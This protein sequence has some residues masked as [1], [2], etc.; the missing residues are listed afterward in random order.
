WIADLLSIPVTTGF[1]AGISIHIIISQLPGVLGLPDPASHI[2][3]QRLATLLGELGRTNPYTLAIG[4]GLLA[5]ILMSERI[6]SRIPGALIGLVLATVAVIALDLERRGV[7][8]LGDV[9]GAFPVPS[10]PAVSFS[11]V[12]GLIPLTLIIVVTIMMQTAATTRSFPSRPDEPPDVDRDFIGV[13]AGSVLAG[14]I[15]AFPVD[16]SPPRTAIVAESG[17]PPPPPPPPPAPP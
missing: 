9:H 2:M 15:G 4:A 17:G 13:G 5:T 12:A 14:L 1:L 3:M 10:L 6:D 11:R 7:A 8:V 16:A